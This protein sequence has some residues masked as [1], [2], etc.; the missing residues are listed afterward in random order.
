M[1]HPWIAGLVVVVAGCGSSP[2]AGPDAAGAA[3]AARVDAEPPPPGELVASGLVEPHGI[4]LDGDVAYLAAN[5]G[6]VVRVTLATGALHAITTG[7]PTPSSLAVTPDEVCWLYTGSHAADF[8]DGSIHCTAKAGGDRQLATAYMPA[9]LAV[10]AD[11]GVLYWV[12]IDG[13][14]VQ[15]IDLD[16]TGQVSLQFSETAKTNVALTPTTLVWAASGAGPDVVAMD[17][18]TGEMTTLS[19]DEYSP[20]ALAVIGADVFWQERSSVNGD[21]AVR[22]SRAGAAPVDLV[23]GEYGADGLVTD[24]T[25][26]YWIDLVEATG[27]YRIRRVLAAGGAAE[28]VVAGLDHPSGLALDDQFVY[29][30]EFDDGTVLRAAR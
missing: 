1:R 19:S 27:R 28:T 20:G 26:L 15:R 14:N 8:L 29:W 12:E 5:D 24:G 11:A 13:G 23:P 6:E 10:D 22:V 16:G 25:W 4:V 18:A 3:D 30:T 17:R 2:A 21:G 7:Q 9:E